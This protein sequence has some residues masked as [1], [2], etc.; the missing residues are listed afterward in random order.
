MRLPLAGALTIA[1]F[2]AHAS[3]SAQR[4]LQAHHELEGTWNGATMTPL[5]RP[6]GF[7][8]R[9]AFTAEEAAEYRRSAPERARA[10]LPSADD[11]LTQADVDDSFVEAE[12]FALDGLRTS[13]IVDPPTGMLPPLVAAARARVASR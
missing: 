10:G 13:L 2:A 5:Q 12:V 11:R 7:E 3:T 6:R 1:F 4:T 8:N 9:V